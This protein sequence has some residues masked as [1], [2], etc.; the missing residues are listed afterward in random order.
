MSR[1]SAGIKNIISEAK[2][3]VWPS[4]KRVYNDTLVVVAALIVSSL[5]VAALD[6]GF[7]SIFRLVI[8]KI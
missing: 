2:A 1:V 7:S 3:I 8:S 5:I 4:R 6:Y